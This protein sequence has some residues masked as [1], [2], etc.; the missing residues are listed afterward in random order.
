MPLDP[1]QP[2]QQIF[3]RT[4]R[5]YS[6]WALDSAI[7]IDA[8]MPSFLASS[9]RWG[10]LR[11]QVLFLLLAQL[12]NTDLADR[13]TSGG[14]GESELGND[15]LARIGS[16]ISSSRPQH[17]LKSLLG[18]VPEGLIGTLRRLGHEPAERS[19]CY[20]TLLEIYQ[21]NDPCDRL[22]VRL[23]G[24]T[25][26]ALKPG[27]IAALSV[28]DPVLLHP[29]VLSRVKSLSEAQ[30]INNAVTFVR[31]RCSTA[32]SAALRQS[33]D[34]LEDKHKLS[35]WLRRWAERCDGLAVETAMFGSDPTLHVLGSGAALI[36][37]G[38]RYRNCLR[39]KIGE[40]VTGRFAYLEYCPEPGMPG[41]IAELR[42]TNH[43]YVLDGLYARSNGHLTREVAAALRDRL[44]R[45]GVSIRCHVPGNEEQLAATAKLL[46]I[47]DW[48]NHDREMAWDWENDLEDELEP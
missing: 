25:T 13:I 5:P 21:S 44:A 46:G 3:D 27:Q 45:C 24:Q 14:V 48:R 37:A 17:L 16:A 40:T 38:R 6:G 41:A 12:G 31:D 11:R 2:N 47:Y 35:S 26:G 18:A 36:N 43:G 4:T 30:S 8:V 22:R 33:L 10:A 29:Q 39:S 23:L 19:R 15:P 20:A 1:N 34:H 28:L 7:Q 9:Y 32:N 42:R